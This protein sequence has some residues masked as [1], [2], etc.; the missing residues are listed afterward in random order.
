MDVPKRLHRPLVISRRAVRKYFRQRVVYPWELPSI[1]RK[2]IY[3]GAMGNIYFTL[4]TGI[5]FIYYGNSVGMTP[6]HWGLMGGVSS[7]ILTSQIISAILTERFG[8]RKLI[9]FV[10]AMAGRIARVAAILASMVLWRAG[11]P[12]AVAVLIGGVWLSNLFDALASPP[13]MSWL[14][15]IIPAREHGGFWGRRSAWIALSLVCTI[16]PAGYLMDRM[17]EDY[18]AGTAVAIFFAAGVL[19]IV[20]LVI[21]GT[22]PEPQAV[23]TGPAPLKERLLAPVLDRGYRPW[24][25]FNGAWTF[26]MSLGGSLGTLY[27]LNELGIKKNFLGGTIVLASLPLVGSLMSSAWSGRLVDRFGPR[28]ILWWG[29]LFWAMLPAFWL[30]ATPSTA[31]L[32]LGWSS[33]QG[34][35]SSTAAV[36]AA[37]KLITRYP[38]PEDRAI[39]VAVSSCIGNVAAGLGALTAGTTI[40]LLGEA[41]FDLFG[42]DV[43]AFHLLFVASLCLRSTS[44]LTLIRRIKNP[45]EGG[46][47]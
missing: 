29:H 18:K 46:R 11:F 25:I 22:L 44:A 28:R 15:D 39:Y 3:T 43:S 41:P 8:R 17:P 36:N 9:W 5:F 45:P 35:L 33:L 6:F 38:K 40:R 7:F 37:N 20:D 21:H 32:W 10:T 30:F 4:I 19:G 26:S 34:G 42:L 16:V 23:T 2:H 14:A 24:L 13:W 1:M 27:F 12:H 31:L 47:G